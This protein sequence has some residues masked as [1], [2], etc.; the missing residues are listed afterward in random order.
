MQLIRLRR[1]EIQSFVDNS[2]M[3]KVSSPKSFASPRDQLKIAIRKQREKSSDELHEQVLNLQK[4]T[5]LV[6]SRI[7]EDFSEI[8][9]LMD[10]KPNKMLM[11][12]VLS[13]H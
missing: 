4:S 1:F 3:E 11:M 12:N 5:N 10:Y 6:L 13:R 8:G 9:Q 2:K 7:K